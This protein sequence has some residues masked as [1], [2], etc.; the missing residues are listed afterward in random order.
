[1]STTAQRNIGVNAMFSRVAKDS[2]ATAAVAV[3]GIFVSDFTNKGTHKI[4]M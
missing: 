4:Y 3:A 1:M 2:K